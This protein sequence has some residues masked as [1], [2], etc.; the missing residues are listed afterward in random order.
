MPSSLRL[1]LSLTAVV[2]SPWPK[3]KNS[4]ETGDGGSAVTTSARQP[5]GL[6]QVGKVDFEFH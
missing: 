4:T 2:G 6:R 1:A 5:G 3:K